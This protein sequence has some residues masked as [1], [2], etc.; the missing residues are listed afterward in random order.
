MLFSVYLITLFHP[1]CVFASLQ[2]MLVGLANVQI[3]SLIWKNTTDLVQNPKNDS[4]VLGPFE[5]LEASKKY[6]CTKYD[7]FFLGIQMAKVFSIKN[8]SYL[9]AP[10][11]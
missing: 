7:C 3:A 4:I 9:S 10:F 6:D 11:F 5:Y 2:K 8:S 1:C